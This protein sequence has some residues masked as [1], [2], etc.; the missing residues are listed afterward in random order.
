MYIYIIY[1]NIYIYIILY[2][3]IYS[4]LYI[5]FYIFCIEHRSHQNWFA[6][7]AP[8]LYYLYMKQRR[9][10]R[11]SLVAHGAPISWQ[12]RACASASPCAANMFQG[13]R[14]RRV[15]RVQ[16]YGGVKQ[17]HT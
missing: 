1:N 12:R 17:Q 6:P 5:I 15:V 7:V 10:Q 16:P 4:Y 11:K 13:L 8:T 3:Y 14:H 2:I 9:P